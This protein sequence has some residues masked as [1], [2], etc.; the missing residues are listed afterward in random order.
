MAKTFIAVHK[1]ILE[2]SCLV[3][4]CVSPTNI[5]TVPIGFNTEKRAAKR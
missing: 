3:S 1:E 4:F 2:R 5:G